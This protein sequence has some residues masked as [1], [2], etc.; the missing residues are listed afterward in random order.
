MAVARSN[1][2][3]WGTEA[4]GPWFAELLRVRAEQLGRRVGVTLAPWEMAGGYTV[5]IEVESDPAL[6]WLYEVTDW[7]DGVRVLDPH[8]EDL[9]ID[10]GVAYLDA[11][12]AGNSPVASLRLAV[13]RRKS[14]LGRYLSRR[15]RLVAFY[16]LCPACDHDWREHPGGSLEPA[17]RKCGEC[18]FELEHGER[19]PSAELCGL[20]A[21]PPGG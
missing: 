17:T 12:C 7:V 10:Q 14:W 3:S 15:H 18:Q 20:R 8:G 4:S 16:G 9:T 6:S 5:E 13:P 19:V 21:P 1:G 2:C 11:R